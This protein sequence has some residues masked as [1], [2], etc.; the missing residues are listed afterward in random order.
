MRKYL[1][2]LDA[3]TFAAFAMVLVIVL[4]GWQLV[5]QSQAVDMKDRQIDALI[6]STEAKDAH[7]AEDRGVAS[8]ERQTL[9]ANQAALLAYTKDLADRQTALLA[10]L[11]HNGVEIPTRYVIDVRAPKIVKVPRGNGK[12]AGSVDR[13]G[14]SER[15]PGQRKRGKR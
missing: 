12:R 11:R 1:R 2:G 6:A 14:K 7:A 8:A 5:Q 9:M 15:A 13:P 10:W 4:V 3:R